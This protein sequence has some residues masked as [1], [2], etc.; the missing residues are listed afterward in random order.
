MT[1]TSLAFVSIIFVLLINKLHSYSFTEI[2]LMEFYFP[3]HED[4]LNNWKRIGSI[5]ATCEDHTLSTSPDKRSWS[6]DESDVGLAGVCSQSNK[7]GPS[8]W[9]SIVSSSNQCGGTSQTPINLVESQAQDDSSLAFPDFE[10]INGGCNSWTS[11]VDDH[12][13]EISISDVGAVCENIKVTYNGAAYIMLQVHFHSPSEHAINGKLAAAEVH[14]VHK[15]VVTGSLLVVGALMEVDTK[16]KSNNDVLQMIWETTKT[17]NPSI[18]MADAA[19]VADAIHCEAH[20][21]S[22]KKFNAY[23][24][25]PKSKDYYTY[26]GS[27]TTYPCTEGVKWI[28]FDEAVKISSLDLQVLR[29]SVK[30]N[31]ETVISPAGNDNRPV[32]PLNGRVVSHYNEKTGKGKGG[33]GGAD[34][35]GKGGA[36]AKGK[37]GADAKGKGGADAKGKDGSDAKGKGGADAKGKGGKDDAGSADKGA[38]GGSGAKGKGA[39]GMEMN[40]SS[41]SSSRRHLRQ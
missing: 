4:M 7:C 23:S 1:T 34:A 22:T 6:Y 13:F 21:T 12:A 32:Q 9:A 35:K 27:L 18:N 17:K 16:A 19:A 5:S 10:A 28:V 41:S 36:D 25:L 15:N 11:F 33:K 2:S 30:L 20:V 37:G 24:I 14:L 8:H 31:P 29:G 3:N 39:K 40:A 26:M 38:K